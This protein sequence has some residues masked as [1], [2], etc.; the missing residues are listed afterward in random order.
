[1]IAELQFAV[2]PSAVIGSTSDL[3]VG[4]VNPNEG[5]L[6]WSDIDGS[7]VFTNLP[8][9]YN[10]NG[11]VDTA[12]YTVWRDMKGRSVPNYTGADGNGDGVVDDLDYDVWVDNFGLTL[13]GAGSGSTSG[14]TVASTSNAASGPTN[15][16]PSGSQAAAT[17]IVTPVDQSVAVIAESNKVIL[18]PVAITPE[19]DV[20][21]ERLS[22]PSTVAEQPQL[23]SPI[24][25]AV[26][27]APTSRHGGPAANLPAARD[28]AIAGWLE[29]LSV[30]QARGR[31]RHVTN[32]ATAVGNS[33]GAAF[34]G[35][36]QWDLL[37]SRV[38]NYRSSRA[39]A[40]VM[41]A[42]V[43]NVDGQRAC[44]AI[45]EFFDTLDEDLSASPHTALS[46]TLA[47]ARQA[48][49]R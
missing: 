48:A 37:L 46:R 45:D 28:Q 20:A 44:V 7:V 9:D 35:V 15:G 21:A 47:R 14:S 26:T 43:E 39:A 40:T 49:S 30:P 18:A 4:P 11:T 36:R 38:D 16:S 5:G 31:A 23:T 34:D 29:P 13:P 8:G 2:S 22:L 6:T 32:G 10:Q 1:V 3:D 12:D 41:A 33:V 25:P 24:S 17:T 27:A 19:L 42:A